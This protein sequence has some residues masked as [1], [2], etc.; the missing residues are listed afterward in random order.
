M[1][2]EHSFGGLECV[3]ENSDVCRELADGVVRVGSAR[4]RETARSERQHVE[5]VNERRR[6]AVEDVSAI[7]EPGHEEKYRA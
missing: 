5:V 3:Q 1:A 6:E 7:A 4:W 2:N